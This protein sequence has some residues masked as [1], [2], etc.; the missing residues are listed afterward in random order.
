MRRHKLKRKVSFLLFSSN[1]KIIT[2]KSAT[3]VASRAHQVQH[4]WNM[5]HTGSA[6]IPVEQHRTIS[7]CWSKMSLGFFKCNVDVSFFN[8]QGLTGVV[9]E[10]TRV[11][12]RLR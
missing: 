6:S 7:Q 1:E 9:S 4:E 5:A 10:M 2:S 3:Q 11:N 8:D 12:L